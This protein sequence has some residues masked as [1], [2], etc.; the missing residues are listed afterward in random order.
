MKVTNSKTIH[1]TEKEVREAIGNWLAER[2]SYDDLY[3]QLFTKNKS[4]LDFNHD[5]SLFIVVDGEIEE[6]N[7]E[8]K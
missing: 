3:Y 2:S 1:L 7:S 4:T 5:G 8:K 6:Y